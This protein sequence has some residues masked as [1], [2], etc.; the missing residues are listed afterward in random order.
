MQ[1]FL[2]PAVAD[3]PARHRAGDRGAAQ[4]RRPR[5]LRARSGAAGARPR[6]LSAPGGRAADGSCSTASAPKDAIA[7][8]VVQR[9]SASRLAAAVTRA[10]LART[11]RLSSA[12]ARTL[13]ASRRSCSHRRPARRPRRQAR[14]A[15]RVAAN[16]SRTLRWR[17]AAGRPV[18]VGGR[19]DAAQRRH[20][21][22]PRCR[23][24]SAAWLKPRSR[25]RDGW[26]GTGTT[27]A[28]P[29]RT[30]APRARISARQRPGQRA[31]S[32]VLQRVDDAR[33]APS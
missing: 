7:A 12:P 6:Q 17:C 1:K 20:D 28:A 32:V 19:A 26:S 2:P 4:G 15:A 10:H 30:S 31:A 3:D 11:P 14:A 23:A 8:D 5:S 29:A 18:C 16:A 33:S 22:Q 9:A 24:R 21:R 27:Q 13:R 25:R